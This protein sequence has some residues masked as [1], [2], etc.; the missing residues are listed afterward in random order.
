MESVKT[1]LQNE[2]IEAME[3]LKERLINVSYNNLLK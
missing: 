1:K 2:K 3:T